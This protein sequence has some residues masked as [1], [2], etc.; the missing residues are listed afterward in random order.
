MILALGNSLTRSIVFFV[1]FFVFLFFRASRKIE[2]A[3]VDVDCGYMKTVPIQ[4]SLSSITDK[5]GA[6]KKKTKN[7]TP[8]GTWVHTF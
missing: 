8:T 5:S 3:D 2:Q 7:K 6:E 1:L 4:S